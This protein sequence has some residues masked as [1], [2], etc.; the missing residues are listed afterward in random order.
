ML[1]RLLFLIFLTVGQNKLE[2]LSSKFFLACLRLG[3]P[4]IIIIIDY[5]KKYFH[6]QHTSLFSVDSCRKKIHNIAALCQ[7]YKTFIYFSNHMAKKLECLYS[8]FFSGL[9]MSEHIAFKLT[10][11]T[12]FPLTNAL[13][14]F[15]LF[16]IDDEKKFS[17]FAT[18]FSTT[19]TRS[20]SCRKKDLMTGN[21]FGSESFGQKNIWLKDIWPKTFG[22]K[23]FGLKTFGQ[24]TF[25]WKTFGWK[26]FGWK[27]FGWKTFGQ[28]TFGWKVFWQKTFGKKILGQ[29]KHLAEKTFGW[30]H[31]AEK[32]F[33]QKKLAENIWPK[34]FGQKTFGQ[35]H[36]A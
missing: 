24:K 27:T 35:K 8:K 12:T 31:L 9:S 4:P 19:P 1:W 13:A 18:R 36:M 32:T 2:C 21:L 34:T 10:T 11:K 28:K 14:Y 22:Q 16:R 5:L 30:K 15:T 29:K 25:G 20:V 33:G 23:T 26:T 3:T 17:N 6:G 7:C